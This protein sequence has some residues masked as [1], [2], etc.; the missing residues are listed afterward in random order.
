M[1]EKEV[2]EKVIEVKEEDKKEVKEEIKE[3][4]ID[5]LEDEKTDELVVEEGFAFPKTTV[6][7]LMR[8]HLE[9]GKQIKGIVK[10]EMNK[11]ME[12][13]VVR[14]TSKMNEH[15]Y[16]YV[17]YGMFKEAI[18]T[19]EKIEDIEQEK[20]RI[21]KYLEKIKADCDSLARDVDRKFE[22]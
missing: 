19:Y 4:D 6:V 9:P 10:R 13:M 16:T 14:V 22:V 12:K 20:I 8:K 17:D 15:P 18:E 11:W 3:E 21:I 2:K 5:D 7:R 1:S